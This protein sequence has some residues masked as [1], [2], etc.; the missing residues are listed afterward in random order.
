D[1]D[2][3]L[4]EEDTTDEEEETTT[5]MLDDVDELDIDCGGR[6][7]MRITEQTAKQGKC[8]LFSIKS[9]HLVLYDAHKSMR[10]TSELNLTADSNNISK[11]QPNTVGYVSV[12]LPY[13]IER[14]VHIP[15][16]ETIYVWSNENVYKVIKIKLSL[17]S[18]IASLNAEKHTWLDAE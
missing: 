5:E 4:T 11:E 14:C 9:G 17:A 2:N 12:S 3:E 1:Q 15:G 7:E 10:K 13:Q 8:Y 18:K 16:S 6:V